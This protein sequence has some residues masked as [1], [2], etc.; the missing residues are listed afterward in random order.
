MIAENLITDTLAPLRLEDTGQEALTIMNLFGVRHLPLVDRNSF[1]A[2]ISEDDILANDI[3]S[4]IGNYDF[5][6][7]RK[8]IY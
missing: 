5:S 8:M 2:L 7:F 3:D 6:M 1:K 4:P